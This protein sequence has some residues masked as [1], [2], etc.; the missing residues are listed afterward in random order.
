MAAVTTIASFVLF[1]YDSFILPESYEIFGASDCSGEP[2]NPWLCILLN[3][4]LAVLNMI[5]SIAVFCWLDYRREYRA[6][7]GRK[8]GKMDTHMM[9]LL[10]VYYLPIS[11]VTFITYDNTSDACW[12]LIDSSAKTD[13]LSFM[14]GFH[15]AVHIIVICIIFICWVYYVEHDIWSQPSGPVTTAVEA[16]ITYTVYVTATP[17]VIPE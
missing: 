7:T 1:T 16:P 14:T 15:F 2:V 13:R 8:T 6:N 4:I 17:H 12:K 3:T 11:V 10:Y 9:L 5:A